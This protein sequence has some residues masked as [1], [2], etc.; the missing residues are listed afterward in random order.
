MKP[1]QLPHPRR[2]G[3]EERMEIRH[4]KAT[5]LPSCPKSGAAFL[6]GTVTQEM[7]SEWVAKMFYFPGCTITVGVRTSMRD[8][9]SLD[10]SP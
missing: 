6:T 4:L 1:C 2:C 3:M 9:A 5:V 8:H 7:K 10:P